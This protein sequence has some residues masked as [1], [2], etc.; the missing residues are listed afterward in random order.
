M[1]DY[2]AFIKLI[3]PRPRMS[4][5]CPPPTLQVD[6]T[7]DGSLITPSALPAEQ[8]LLDAKYKIFREA[9]EIQRRWREDIR[10]ASE[11][12]A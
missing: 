2:G 3:S 8:K 4:L 1:G 12:D 6:M 11:I 10:V 7:Q 9:I 5:T